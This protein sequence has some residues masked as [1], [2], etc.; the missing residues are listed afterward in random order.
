[1]LQRNQ[2]RYHVKSGYSTYRGWIQIDYQRSNGGTNFILR[3]KEQE[4][5]LT[6]HEHDDDYCLCLNSDESNTEEKMVIRQTL[7]FSINQTGSVRIT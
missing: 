5:R 2:R 7:A 4:T 1:M 3:T 6:L